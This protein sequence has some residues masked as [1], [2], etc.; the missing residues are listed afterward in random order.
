MEEPI[1]YMKQANEQ[2]AYQDK[3][4]N[5][6]DILTCRHTESR[7]QVQVG[8]TTE[9]D[10]EG[11]GIE[12]PVYESQVVINK[13]WDSFDSLEEAEEAYGLTK[14]EEENDGRAN[15]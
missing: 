8:T 10:E 3:D 11:N 6:Y 15:D 9:T 4:G 5:R 7:E 1:V 13:G 12:V 2:G 14:V